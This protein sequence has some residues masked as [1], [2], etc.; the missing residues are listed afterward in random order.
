MNSVSKGGKADT[1]RTYLLPVRAAHIAR[2]MKATTLSDTTIDT[3][4][5]RFKNH[6]RLEGDPDH[7]VMT[8]CLMK[9]IKL[10]LAR[11]KL[12]RCQENHLGGSSALNYTQPSRV[13][14]TWH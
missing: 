4:L 5:K 13:R 7:P 2:G 3:A 14:N 10:G 11:S 12:S 1:V 8:L 6:E 9:K